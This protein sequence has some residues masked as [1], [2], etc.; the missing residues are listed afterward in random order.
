LYNGINR[1]QKSFGFALQAGME[2]PPPC[3]HLPQI[4]D[5]KQTIGI[6]KKN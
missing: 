4:H 3:G 2:P 1:L 6:K 5:Q